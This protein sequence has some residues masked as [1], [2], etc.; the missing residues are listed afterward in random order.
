ML[1]PELF[2]WQENLEVKTKCMYTTVQKFE[3]SLMFTLE[4]MHLFD[5]KYCTYF[6]N[7]Y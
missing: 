6:V 4:R 1:I 5:Q 7:Y 3:K 2:I